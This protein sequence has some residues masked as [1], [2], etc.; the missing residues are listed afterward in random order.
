M[1]KQIKLP[2]NIRNDIIDFMVAV[3]P[4]VQRLSADACTLYISDGYTDTKII[5]IFEQMSYWLRIMELHREQ[6]AYERIRNEIADFMLL[7]ELNKEI[8]R[9]KRKNPSN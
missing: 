1:A 8:K 4:I 9:D 6:I 3:M 2:T 7:E 5:K